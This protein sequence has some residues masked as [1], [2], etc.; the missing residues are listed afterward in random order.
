MKLLEFYFPKSFR[1]IIF[2]SILNGINF[3]IPDLFLFKN[4]LTIIGLIFFGEGSMII[5]YWIEKQKTKPIKNKK[6]EEYEIDFYNNNSLN[7]SFFLVFRN[8]F[9]YGNH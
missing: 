1:L 4:P 9:V 2:A 6:N 5:F 3:L 8:I 7:K